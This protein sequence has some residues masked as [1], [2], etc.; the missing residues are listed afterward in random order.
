[1]SYIVS[2][3]DP[4]QFSHLFGLSNEELAA[5]GALR[6]HVDEG[7]V[8]PERST[9]RDARVG[10]DVLLVNYTYQPALNPYHGRH[11]IFVREGATERAV[12]RDDLPESL[13]ERLI[14]LRAFDNADMLVACEVASGGKLET[15]IA[16]Y[17]VRPEVAYLHA[18]YAAPGCFAAAITRG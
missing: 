10:S 5:S 6:R 14:S 12:V 7:F 16:D 1:M 8:V 9:L 18:H 2:G 15:L 11:A 4:T 13:R 17:L 3:V